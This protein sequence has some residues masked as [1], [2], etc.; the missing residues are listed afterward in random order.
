ML[1][2]TAKVSQGGYDSSI[3]YGELGVLS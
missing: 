2:F 3:H 1:L